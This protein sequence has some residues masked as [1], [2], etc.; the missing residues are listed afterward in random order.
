L[1]S[2]WQTANKLVQNPNCNYYP[3]LDMILPENFIE[4][5]TIC[6]LPALKQVTEQFFINQ[7]ILPVS[8]QR[9]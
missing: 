8:D 9:F 2:A 4:K 7:A 3:L 5:T 1:L 6:Q